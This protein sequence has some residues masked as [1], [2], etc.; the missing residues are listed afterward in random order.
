MTV[1]N[2]LS[3][4]KE[5]IQKLLDI[6]FDARRFF[7]HKSDE[8]WLDWLWRNG[9]LNLLEEED[10]SHDG[11]RTPELDYL[12]RMAEKRP[13]QVVDIMLA[14]PISTDVRSQEV[15]YGFLRICSALP[16]DQLARVVEKI[17]AERWVPMMEA[18]DHLDF[19]YEEMV[20]KLADA[21]DFKNFLLL[22]EAVLA[23][24]PGEETGDASRFRDSPFHLEHLA[25]TKLFEQLATVNSEY[26]EHAL[27]LTTSKLA[28]IMFE[29]DQFLLFEVDFFTL[30]PGQTDM[31]QEDVRE[32]A[33]AA[34]TLAVRLIGER[35]SES[36]DVRRIYKEH[37]ASLPVSRVM[38]RL[39]LFVLSL[40][41]QVFREELKQILFS[42]FEEENYYDEMDGYYFVMSGAE[43][44]KALRAGF[45][46]LSESDK[47]DYVL[48]TMA[49]FR[50]PADIRYNGSPLLSMILPYFD[51][52]P[53]LRKQVEDAGFQ[54][55]P[56]YE[57]PPDVD[58]GS[59]GEGGF[60]SP[61]GPIHEEELG[62]LTVVEIA[63]K[64][65]QEWTPEELNAQNS[66]ADFYNPLNAQGMDDLLKD[67]IPVRLSEYVESAGLFFERG[68][69]DQHYT[70]SYLM[71][72][73]EAI[74]NDRADASEV[75]WDSVIEL[76]TTMKD[77]GERV[78]LER[79]PR[80]LTGLYA[81]SWLANWDAVHSA[82]AD[83]LRELLAEQDGLTPVDFGRH[84]DRI[85]EIAAYLLSYP[86]PSPA[87][88]QV[89]TAQ[90][91]SGSAN[92]TNY[93]VI[94]PFTMAINSVRGRA[95]QA[96]VQFVFQDG[97]RCHIDAEV[98]I[99]D[100]V[101]ALYESVLQEENTRA[102]MFLYG[103]YLPSFCFGDWDWIRK[104]LPRIFDQE[105]AQRH[106]YTAAWEGY[107]A[108][109]LYGA[110][111][112]EPEI[113]NL[114]Q[115]ALDLTEGD[116]PREQ[117]HF[118]K[119]D[120]GIAQHLALAFM[121]YEEFGFDHQLFKAFWKNDSPKQHAHF[122]NFIG[123]SFISRDKAEESF[124]FS[125]EVKGRLRELWDWLLQNDEKR[126][127]YM[128]FGI[129]MNLDKG[130][131]E[132]I[133][134]ARRVRE[135]LEMAGGLLEWGNELVK[136][137]PQL[138]QAAP[139]DT[140]EIA[141][142]YLHEGGVRGKNQRALWLWESDNQWIETFEILYRNP[143]TKVETEGLINRL[144][145]EGGRAFWPLKR[146]L[147]E[148]P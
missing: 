16:A 148:E 6:N 51:E 82:M 30:E 66:E 95:F 56:D 58:L 77:L 100:D 46:V 94:D 59:G 122:V 137:S 41:P 90:I 44:L 61:R 36:G 129:W 31:W 14:I 116:F 138:A 12:L 101:K 87:D 92:E 88:E 99:F 15:V 119:P 38:R 81:S 115:R 33:A 34:K 55:N 25:R 17:R 83:V 54:L 139:E 86:D 108:N 107:L 47:L 75:E 60:I 18:F 127:V 130:I 1:N 104:L 72:I 124:E 79:G 35:C 69:L 73:Q 27:A 125:R 93:S 64:L 62:R 65:R 132:P 50:Q 91:L 57:P 8:R 7:F 37:L 141:R 114:Y 4:S 52:N 21:K 135:T 145:G 13:A 45:S 5:R 134:L 118:K 147:D 111:F 143:T 40:C 68:V 43:Y 98:R 109:R 106:L 123:R 74:K 29:S 131:F 103:H 84:R 53:A 128:E 26:A 133:W 78:R 9:F 76:F 63:G 113:Q 140:F 39:R 112:S 85:L 97:K 20:D 42:L 71:G 96:F 11:F 10:P 142:L 80:E 136:A 28:E 23:V 144:V 24:R 3:P 105:P 19:L 70:Y 117:R 120:E 146:I 102:L 48:R 32:L 89:E 2:P 126:E 67:D 121:H 22:A 49:T 110:L